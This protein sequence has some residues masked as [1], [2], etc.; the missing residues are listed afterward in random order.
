MT[1]AFSD[2][3]LAPP[4]TMTDQVFRT[5]YDQ[6]VELRLLPG[7]KI[8]ELEVSRLLDV[9]RQPVR[10]AFF[11]LS[12]LGLLTIRPQ[13]ATTVSRIRPDAVLQAVYIRVAVEVETIRAAAT[14]LS[15]GSLAEIERL[16][17]QQDDAVRRSD[18]ALFHALDDDLHRTIFEAA[19]KGFAWALVRDN[20]AHMDRVRY[21]SLEFGAK[22]ALDDHVAIYQALRARNPDVADARLREHLGRIAHV[23][24]KARHE[25]PE[26][27]APS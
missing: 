21:I 6:I 8:S 14:G 26:L 24:E 3:E 16:I 18:K 7:T 20:K 1:I 23:L 12:Q 27:F 10:D 13:R 2:L 17:D 25:R 5:L 22:S 9:S 19:G 15:A 11:R 4:P